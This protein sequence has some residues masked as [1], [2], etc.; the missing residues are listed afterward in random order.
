MRG[1]QE[2]ISLAEKMIEHHPETDRDTLSIL[3]RS[4]S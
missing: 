3:G 4:A 1:T 2:I